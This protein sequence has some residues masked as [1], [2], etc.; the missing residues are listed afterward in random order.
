VVQRTGRAGLMERA[1]ERIVDA[2]ARDDE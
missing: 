1:L 2:L